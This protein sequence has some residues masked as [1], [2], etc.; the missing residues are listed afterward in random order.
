MICTPDNAF[1]SPKEIK[2]IIKKLKR[3]KAP[4][5]DNINNMHPNTLFKKSNLTLT[6]HSKRLFKKLVLPKRIEICKNYF[7]PQTQTIPEFHRI[8][9][10]SQTPKSNI[11]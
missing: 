10:Q 8:N 9:K 2:G 11:R 3:R 1:T 5:V 6:L 4:G 7:F